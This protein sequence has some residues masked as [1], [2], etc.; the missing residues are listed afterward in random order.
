MWRR[1][2][3]GSAY[4][5][6]QRREAFA[7]GKVGKQGGAD[8][9]GAGRRQRADGCGRCQPGRIVCMDPAQREKRSADIVVTG[10]CESGAQAQQACGGCDKILRLVASRGVRQR[11]RIA[12]AR[13]QDEFERPRGN[14]GRVAALW[15]VG[16]KIAGQVGHGRAQAQRRSFMPAFRR[17]MP[18][19]D[20]RH[21]LVFHAVGAG[22]ENRTGMHRPVMADPYDL[23]SGQHIGCLAKHRQGADPAAAGTQGSRGDVPDRAHPGPLPDLRH[24]APGGCRRRRP[25][26]R[27]HVRAR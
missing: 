22:Y 24:R 14:Q 15:Q 12:T 11:E 5:I 9:M 16:Q 1:I 6:V 27:R 18:G 8:G 23:V 25:A 20:F 19:L 10:W 3:H 13:L 26:H 2:G 17:W 4:Q 21:E 7:I